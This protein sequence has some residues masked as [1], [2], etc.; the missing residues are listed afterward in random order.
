MYIHAYTCSI[1]NVVF[2]QGNLALPAGRDYDSKDKWYRQKQK[3]RA[4]HTSKQ[5]N[6]QGKHTIW[7]RSTSY[8]QMSTEIYFFRRRACRYVHGALPG[9]KP[10]NMWNWETWLGRNQ[11]MNT[12]ENKNMLNKQTRNRETQADKTQ[13]LI[14]KKAMHTQ[15]HMARNKKKYRRRYT[16]KQL[17]ADSTST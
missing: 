10:E 12:N 11:A 5:E 16:I 13:H 15:T 9:N 3:T 14:H 2:A 4:S 7:K 1:R 8:I 6:I 17:A